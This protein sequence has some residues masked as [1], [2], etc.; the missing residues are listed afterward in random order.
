MTVKRLGGEIGIDSTYTNG[1]RFIFRI[2]MNHK[3][4]KEM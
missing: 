2:P 1:T 4:G 3:V